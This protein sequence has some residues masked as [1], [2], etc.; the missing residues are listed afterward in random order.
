MTI[1]GSLGI[2]SSS[3]DNTRLRPT[4]R[5]VI[6]KAYFTSFPR[7]HA[8]YRQWLT[9]IVEVFGE[10]AEYKFRKGLPP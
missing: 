9:L 10:L 1:P 6:A 5:R 2:G 4:P 8:H 7:P 3:L